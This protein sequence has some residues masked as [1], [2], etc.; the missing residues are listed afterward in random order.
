MKFEI[1]RNSA[2][3]WRWRLEY[4]DG[5]V[6]ADSAVSYNNKRDCLQAIQLVMDISRDTPIHEQAANVV[7]PGWYL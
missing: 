1:Y 2:G 5:M 6:I 7:G 4:A 3:G